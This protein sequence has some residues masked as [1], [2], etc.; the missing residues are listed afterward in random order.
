MEAARR[1]YAIVLAD[2]RERCRRTGFLV[3]LAAV[4]IATWWCFPPADAGYVTVAVGDARGAYSPAWI[5]MVL[6]LVHAVILGLAGFYIV[7]GTITRDFETRVWQLLVATPMTRFGWLL[8]KWTSHLALLS[9]LVGVGLLV[10][11]AAQ[12]HR[13]ES[14]AIAPWQLL[15]PALVLTLPAMALT[16]FFAVLFDV[17]PW[18]RRSG[19]NVLYFFLWVFVF[20]SPADMAADAATQAAS[21]Y[22]EPGGMS[23]AMRDIRADLQ[24]RGLPADGGFSIGVSIVEGGVTT[25]AWDRWS[26]RAADVGGRL[27]WVGVSL[28]GLLALAPLLDRAAARSEVRQTGQRAVP[29]LRL[30]WLDLLLAPLDRFGFGRLLA[31]EIR[32]VLRQRRV[33]WWLALLVL[34][35]VQAF[36]PAKGMAIAVIG[37]WLACIDVF[38]RAALRERE[39]GTAAMVFSAPGAGWRLLGVRLAASVLL[40]LGV[41]LPA[42][43]RA[44]MSGSGTLAALVATAVAIAVVGLALAAA[45]RNPRPFELLLVFVAY[46]GVQGDPLLNPF[47]D[48]PATLAR[49]GVVIAVAVAL[50]LGAWAVSIRRH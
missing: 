49:Q 47:A 45:C 21:A 26:P 4:A 40:A 41:V 27:L 5:G 33:S 37:A 11:L 17:V 6:A 1:F 18:L 48:P 2:F 16:A 50:L 3:V 23:L 19:G 13:G 20:V 30:A 15:Q 44:G 43:V 7:R 9:L 32:L 10:G 35:A 22:S 42:L 36:A 12:F 28:L 24:A 8:A 31:A 38:A 34:L 25:F 39:T 46:I 29:G 14:T